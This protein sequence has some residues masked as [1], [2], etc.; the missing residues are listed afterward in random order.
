ML[1]VALVQNTSYGL[2]HGHAEDH[3]K[4]VELIKFLCHGDVESLKL[5][6]AQLFN[7]QFV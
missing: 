2:Y 1:I 7:Q 5:R 4:C 6:A 3:M